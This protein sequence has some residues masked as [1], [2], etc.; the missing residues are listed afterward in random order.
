MG[1]MPRLKLADALLQP[2]HF[3]ALWVAN[4]LDLDRGRVDLLA[5]AVR[6]QTGSLQI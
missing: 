5:I 1:A 6:E 2:F 3:G 4:D